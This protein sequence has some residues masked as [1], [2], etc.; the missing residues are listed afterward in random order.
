[1]DRNLYVRALR[2][3]IGTPYLWGGWDR[4]GTDCSGCVSFCLKASGFDIPQKL[5]A[6]EL[7]EKFHPNKVI[8]G[9]AQPGTILF[10]GQDV[11]SIDHVMSV[12]TVWGNGGMCIAGA[13]GGGALT[14]S[15]DIAMSQ[16]A[17]VGVIFGNSKLGE[18]YWPSHFQFALDPFRIN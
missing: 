5:C 3:M 11:N 4:S 6:S 9:A 12:L 13:R 2:D 7:A 10:Y 17:L 1:M 8:Y 16:N 15:A 18:F 14:T